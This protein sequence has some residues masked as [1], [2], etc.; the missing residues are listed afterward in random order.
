MGVP[1]KKRSKSRQRSRQ[2]QQK[3]SSPSIGN[4]PHCKAPLLSHF[5]CSECG[6]YKGKQ[7]V[8]IQAKKEKGKGEEKEKGKGKR[9][10]KGK[11]KKK[12]KG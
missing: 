12:E 6:Y 10:E 9:K 3:L 4:C 8:I 11:G 5:V 1:K 2:S 7:A